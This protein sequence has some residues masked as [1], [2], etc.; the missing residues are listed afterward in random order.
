MN[1][2]WVAWSNPVALWWGSLLL[3]SSAN[4]AL[5]FVLR[6]HLQRCA[7]GVLRARFRVELMVML[8]AAYVFGCAFRS[9]L[10][11]ADVQRIVLFDTWLSSVMVGRSVATIAELCFAIQWAIVLYQLGRLACS[12]AARNVSYAVVP[13]IVMAE[14]CSW[15]AVITTSYLGNTI[16]N[17]L[18]AVAFLLV[19]GGLLRL[20]YEFRGF[21]QLAIATAITGIAVYL[22]FL[23]VIDVPMY[24]E[25]WQA[26]LIG[27]KQLLGL[28]AGLH[29]VSARWV[30]THDF[31]QWEDEIAWMTLYF[32]AAVWSSLALCGLGLIADRLAHYRAKRARRTR[33]VRK[34]LP[35]VY[36]PP[37][38]LPAPVLVRS[39]G[40]LNRSPA[41]TPRGR[42]PP[43]LA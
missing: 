14:C 6:R 28:L 32:S 16:E 19:A 37:K 3:V 11:R 33:P 4:I 35:V 36:R 15:Y 24:F 2:E 29:D 22:A 18:W 21:M 7:L 12:D 34:F 23:A 27:G 31:G 5:W 1:F 8:C 39:A 40:R 41:G 13:L 10:P 42:N 25:R 17:S 43:P 38:L 26:D 30:V 20:L 9:A